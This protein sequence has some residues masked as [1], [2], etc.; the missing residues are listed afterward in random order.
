MRANI[1]FAAGPRAGSMQLAVPDPTDRH[2]QPTG[3]IILDRSAS[4]HF[5]I[6]TTLAKR[7]NKIKILII[8]VIFISCATI[9]SVFLYYRRLPD[10]V[11]DLVSSIPVGADLTI[12]DIHQ[13]AT[14]DGRKEWSLDAASAQYLNAEKQV[15]LT[16]LSMTF[17]LEDQQDL[18]LTADRGV[19]LTESKD[20]EI[21]GNIELRG[22]DA[23]LKT[24][25]LRYRHEQRI[26]ASLSPVKITGDSY[27]LTA[28]RMQ[29]DLNTNQA[30]FEGNIN[31]AFIE[32]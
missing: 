22:R 26:L 28:E 10:R 14:R 25:K 8:A 32:D 6:L 3:P 4:G 23:L 31:G 29:L 16:E 20:V 27:R 13:T 9:V 18:K 30:I 11:Q 12:A 17:Y 2:S 21:I 5:A 1:T 7:N 19:L 24:Q 15:I